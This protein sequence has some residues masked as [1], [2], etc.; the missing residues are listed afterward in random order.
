MQGVEE[1]QVARGDPSI[2]EQTSN[3]AFRKSGEMLKGAKFAGAVHPPGNSQK[4]PKLSTTGINNIHNH[5][6]V[7][8]TFGCAFDET[9]AFNTDLHRER[10][11]Y[12]YNM[13]STASKFM[14]N[15]EA[16]ARQFIEKQRKRTATLGTKRM[17]N[18]KKI[19]KVV[20]S[21][22]RTNSSAKDAIAHQNQ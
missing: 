21:S 6:S 1:Q 8:M 5:S 19:Y 15:T 22:D 14:N 4:F 13:T 16:K 3:Y 7:M 9:S 2:T 12:S 20:V 18:H 11:N 17:S 10:K